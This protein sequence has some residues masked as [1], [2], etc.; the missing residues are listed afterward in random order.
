LFDIKKRVSTETKKQRY[1]LKLPDHL[2]ETHAALTKHNS[3]EQLLYLTLSDLNHQ[4]AHFQNKSIENMFKQEDISVL[5][6]AESNKKIKQSKSEMIETLSLH[7]N[8][9]FLGMISMQYKAKIV[10]SRYIFNKKYIYYFSKSKL[11]T[12]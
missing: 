1:A 11:R 8:Q 2:N 9:I 6:S 10:R 3:N 12:L 4:N 7:E 5:E